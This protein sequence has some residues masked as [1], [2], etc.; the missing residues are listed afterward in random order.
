VGLGRDDWQ[1]PRGKF[2]VRSKSLNPTWVIPESIL[3]ERIADKGDTR[4]SIAGGEPDNPLGGHR[5]ALSMPA[6][7]I[8]GTNTPWGVG[9]Q[10]SH[11]CIRLYPEDIERLFPLVP[12]GTPGRFVYQPVKVG[13]RGGE[14]YVEITG[15]IYGLTPAIWREAHSM[16]ERRGVADRVDR[17]R[18]IA[19]LSQPRGIPIRVTGRRDGVTPVVS[20]DTVEVLSD[21]GISDT[22][23]FEAADD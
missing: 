19:A 23:E 22:D 20:V 13:V 16:L 8:H 4:T 1:T 11:G 18:L 2:R 17:E 6:Y 7:A 15:D 10:V 5:L 9:M 14:V 12:V 3:Q 21:A